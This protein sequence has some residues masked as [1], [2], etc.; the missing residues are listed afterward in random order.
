MPPGKHGRGESNGEQ[1]WMLP[2]DHL[3]R[4]L[5]VGEKGT[6]Y[7]S[8]AYVFV[9][10]ADLRSQFLALVDSH[11]SSRYLVRCRCFVKSRDELRLNG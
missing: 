2:R 3:Q 6:G 1:R 8:E 9:T 11:K 7:S 10:D 5:D 4:G